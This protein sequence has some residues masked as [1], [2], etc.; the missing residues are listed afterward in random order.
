MYSDKHYTR[1]DRN[2]KKTFYVQ[3]VLSQMTL[4]ED[5]KQLLEGEPNEKVP[6]PMKKRDRKAK[7]KSDAKAKKAATHNLF[8]A[9]EA[10]SVN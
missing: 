7:K 3:Y 1:A 9:G 8:A 6:A 5:K 10:V 4:L 2:L